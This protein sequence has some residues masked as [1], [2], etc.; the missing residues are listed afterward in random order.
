[1]YVGIQVP[2][3]VVGIY[4]EWEDPCVPRFCNHRVRASVAY[5]SASR[6]RI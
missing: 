3:L 6:S 4:Q 1:M 5:I 2:S